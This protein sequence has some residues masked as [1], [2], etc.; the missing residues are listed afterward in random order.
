MTL[1]EILPA[2]AG[3]A[4]VIYLVRFAAAYDH[5]AS[6][7]WMLP[8][9]LSLIFLAFSVAAVATEGLFGFWT[10]HTRTLW[11]NQVWF[12]LLLAAG[13]AWSLILPQARSLGM[14][15]APWIVAVCLT[16]CIGLL[17]MYARVLYLRSRQRDSSPSILKAA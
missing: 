15:S 2:L 6:S 7:N 14:K 1:T 17:A 12:D 16:G 13:I 9:V 8:A 4:F 3:L 5:S 10:E 11:G